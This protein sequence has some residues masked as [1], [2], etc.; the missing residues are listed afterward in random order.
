[1]L[2]ELASTL[3]AALGVQ[4]KRDIQAAASAFSDVRGGPWGNATVRL[5]DDT[6]A[7]PDGEG[8]LLFAAE[9]MWPELVATEPRFAGYCAVMVNASDVYS[10]GGR[11]LAIVDAL[12]ATS[13]DAAAPVLAGMRDAAAR[14]GV[15]VVGGHTNLHSPYPALAA[16]V[17]GRAKQLLTSFDARPGDVLVAAYDLRGQMHPKHAFWNASLE[18]PVDRLRGDYE[19][20]PAIAEAGLAAAA[21]DVSMGGLVGTTLMLLEA[22]GVGAELELEAIPRPVGVP[23]ERWLLAFPSYGFLLSVAPANVA[24]VCELF[25]SRGLAA[26]AVG[27]VDASRK[28]T[29]ASG[30]A[31]EEIWDLGAE[32]LTGFDGGRT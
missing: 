26:A 4:H 19:V 7:I 14:F 9:G 27:R 13:G 18:G 32:A 11:P 20:L 15:P 28:L 6:A 24:R 31:R 16:A 2:P 29:L 21:K 8:Y 1:M 23:W 25:S 10:M 5:G 3:R 30:G 12:F 22:S 17:L